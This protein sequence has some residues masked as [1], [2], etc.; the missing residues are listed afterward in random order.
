MLIHV[1]TSILWQTSY[2]HVFVLKKKY[3]HFIINK[4]FRFWTPLFL[5]VVYGQLGK[6][7]T[8]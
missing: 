7:G 2:L 5:H 8:L 1:H 4:A 3:V 6:L